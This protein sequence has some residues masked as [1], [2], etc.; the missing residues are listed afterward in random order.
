MTHSPTCEQPPPIVTKG[1]SVDIAKCPTCGAITST[2]R[3][4]RTPST[5]TITKEK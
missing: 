2:T 5:T 3:H 4:G 1:W